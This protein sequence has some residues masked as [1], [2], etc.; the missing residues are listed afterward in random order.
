LGFHGNLVSPIHQLMLLEHH[1]LVL[2]LLFL[3]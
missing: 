2:L 3:Q 1:E